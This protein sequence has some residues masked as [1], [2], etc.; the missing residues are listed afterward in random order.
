MAIRK[1][2]K[3][4]PQFDGTNTPEN[5]EFPSIGIEDIDR[6]VF[7]LFDEKLN[8]QTTQKKESRKVPVVF[9]TGERF[10]LTRRKDPIRDR[11][12]AIILPIISIMREGIDFSP[13]QAGKKTAIAFREQI[14]YTIKKRLAE[15]DRNYQNILNK[16]GLRN[17][18]NVA[19]RRNFLDNS[20]FPGNDA[21]AGSVASRKNGKNLS[22][23]TNG[24]TISLAE[25]LNKN[26]YE[27]IEIPYPD[28]VA[29][30]YSVVF[31]TQYLSQANDMMEYLI[32]S[33][34]GQGEEITMKT[35]EGFELVAFF[36]NKFSSNNNFDSGLTDSE[37]IIKHTINLT[38]PGYILNP[39][40]SGLPN[41]LRSYFSAPIIDFGYDEPN[42]DVV[43]NNQPERSEERDKRLILTDLTA[44]EDLA[45]LKRGES[46]EDLQHYVENPFTRENE[47]KFSKVLTTNKRSGESVIS[48]LIVDKIE[49]QYEWERKD[50]WIIS[51]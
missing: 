43:F 47:V 23:S 42:T 2:D 22:F 17:Q 49:R 40:I 31:W 33:F 16:M 11:N 18:E 5:F 25:N 29:I 19:A 32:S 12:N 26:I 44:Q 38:V 21:V 41:S 13:D 27:I 8:F 3:V 46:S 51:W 30:S 35:P 15:S 4:I 10:A 6:A 37:R 50:N 20:I 34:E 45:D 28:F 48:S 36:D 14:S 24:G 1:G 39:K 9:A 7:K